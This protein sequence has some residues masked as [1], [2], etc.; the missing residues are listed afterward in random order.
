MTTILP[1][2]IGMDYYQQHFPISTGSYLPHI[3]N[4]VEILQGVY[5]A[6]HNHET[7]QER[8]EYQILAE[9]LGKV[10]QN[11]SAISGKMGIPLSDLARANLY[12]YEQQQSIE[13]HDDQ[14]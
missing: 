1:P 4:S 2:D 12:R 5:D 7:N 9:D 11:I 8:V 14:D 6:L 3:V 10:L 13:E